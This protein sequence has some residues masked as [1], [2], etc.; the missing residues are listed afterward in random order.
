[1]PAWLDH[2]KNWYGRTPRTGDTELML[3]DM[4]RVEPLTVDKRKTSEWR[5]M[6]DRLVIQPSEFHRLFMQ[7]PRPRDGQVYYTG[8][9]DKIKPIGVHGSE[10]IVIKRL[11]PRK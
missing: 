6:I 1:M 11:T 2:H 4:R 9:I 5:D 8:G 10:M 3:D 7:E